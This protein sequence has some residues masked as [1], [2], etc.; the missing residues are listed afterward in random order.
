MQSKWRNSNGA[1]KWRRNLSCK[2]RN[3]TEDIDGAAM[4]KGFAAGAVGGLIG[5]WLMTKTHKLLSKAMAGGC[6]DGDCGCVGHG[7]ESSIGEQQFERQP[8]LG[9]D[10]ATAKTAGAISQAMLN[11]ELT[12]DEQRF[13]APAVHYGFGALMGGVYGAITGAAPTTATG[14]GLPFGALLWLV[15]DELAVPAL[16]LGKP[17]SRR[18]IAEHSAMLAAHLVYGAATDV[19]R[20]GLVAAMED[21]YVHKAAEYLPDWAARRPRDRASALWHRYGK[22]L[23]ALTGKRRDWKHLLQV[24]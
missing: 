20:R 1:A 17:R 21:G 5:S 22:S 11:R 13:A 4:L 10:P 18:P 9:S 15:G 16:N 14:A 19:V 12:A 23:P 8:G 2:V 3:V 6:T 7:S 24:A